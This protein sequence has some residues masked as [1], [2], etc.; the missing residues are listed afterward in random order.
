MAFHGAHKMLLLAPSLEAYRR[1]V[2]L[3][4]TAKSLRLA[5]SGALSILFMNTLQVLATRKRHVNVL[6]H[7][8]GHLKQALD[9]DSK[10]E[11]LLLDTT[12]AVLASRTWPDR[13]TSIRT[14]P[15]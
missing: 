14:P 12:F 4:A 1:L 8:M 2:R 13:S 9:A 11:L 7:M 5:C 10:A 15:S 3:V 6:H